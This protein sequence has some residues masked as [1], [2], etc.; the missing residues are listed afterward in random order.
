MEIEIAFFLVVTLAVFGF[1][2]GFVAREQGAQLVAIGSSRSL[3][4][5]SAGKSFECFADL[6]YFNRFLDIELDCLLYTSD[7]ADE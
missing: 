1:D 6:I 7:A 2:L 3:G 4:G 5:E